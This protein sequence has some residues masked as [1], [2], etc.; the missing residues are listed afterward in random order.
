M[1]VRK[2][3]MQNILT[4]LLYGV[5]MC[6]VTLVP[7]VVLEEFVN[8]IPGA[9]S[10]VSYLETS[11][12]PMVLAVGLTTLGIVVVL[13]LVG[14]VAKEYLWKYLSRLP[15]FTRFTNS[16]DRMSK[17]LNNTDPEN[18]ERVVWIAWPSETVQTLGV[19]TEADDTESEW[20]TV[21]IFSTSGQL[22]NGLL[23]RVKVDQ[24]TYP[25]WTIDEALEFVLTA[26][27]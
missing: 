7:W 9:N 21:I 27:E 13:V 8:R 22:T 23:R 10:L 19:I 2:E 12:M 1:S 14:Y 15:L 4:Y 20:L 18:R 3:T 24:V 16:V 25:H 26:A 5:A 11:D 17:Q 6:T